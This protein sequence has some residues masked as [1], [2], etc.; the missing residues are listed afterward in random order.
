MLILNHISRHETFTDF[1]GIP[2]FHS[3][4]ILKDMY[5]SQSQL[6]VEL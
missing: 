4:Y 3:S 1:S 2:D 5:R 6:S